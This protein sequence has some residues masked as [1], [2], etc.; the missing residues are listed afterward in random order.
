MVK[1]CVRCRCSVV[2]ALWPVPVVRI[3]GLLCCSAG[4]GAGGAGGVALSFV[5]AFQVFRLAPVRLVYF[6]TS[7]TTCSVYSYHTF[8]RVSPADVSLS[9]NAFAP[10]GWVLSPALSRP[11]S[12]FPVSGLSWASAD[13]GG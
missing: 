7:S 3:G 11:V 5:S 6:S 10:W 9:S 12:L 13:A 2:A 4:Q 8:V 1:L